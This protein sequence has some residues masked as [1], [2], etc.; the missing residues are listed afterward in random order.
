V[1]FQN[2]NLKGVTN[3]GVEYEAVHTL[4]MG[5]WNR[6]PVLEDGF[7]DR[8]YRCLL[9]ECNKLNAEALA[10]NGMEEHTHGLIRIPPTICV[11]DLAHQLKGSSSH[12]VNQV[13]MPANTFKWQGG[14]C[15]LSE[16][17]SMVPVVRAYILN[18]EKHHR[19]GT[20]NKDFELPE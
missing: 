10:V 13:I 17:P 5:T 9:E 1:G 2:L 19:E 14:Y 16:S 8:V 18:Q 11:A 3:A 7:K 15:A 20:V 12:F 4:D 6:L